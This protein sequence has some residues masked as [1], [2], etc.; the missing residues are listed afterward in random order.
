MLLLIFLVS[1]LIYPTDSLKIAPTSD[2]IQP[3]ISTDAPLQRTE[4]TDGMLAIVFDMIMYVF[5]RTAGCY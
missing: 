2:I 5:F 3:Q 1:V 4:K